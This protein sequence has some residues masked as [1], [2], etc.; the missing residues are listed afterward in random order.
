M[1]TNPIEHIR[2]EHHDDDGVCCVGMAAGVTYEEAL[3][4]IFRDEAQAPN[5]VVC[6]MSWSTKPSDI[7]K[8]LDA[9]GISLRDAKLSY[10]ED[11]Y[12]VP[13][14]GAIVA[15]GGDPKSSNFSWVYF[16]AGRVYDP[17]LEEPMYMDDYY[18]SPNAFMAV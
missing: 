13:V 5:V 7:R 2:Q 9:L 18:F 15:V 16:Y 1:P 14:T 3:A 4:A 11:W 8:G 10:T 6:R 17:S 12:N